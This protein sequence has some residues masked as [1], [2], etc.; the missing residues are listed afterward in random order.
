MA[1]RDRAEADNTRSALVYLS[2]GDRLLNQK[3][4]EE[5]IKNYKEV[6]RLL[7]RDTQVQ[8]MLGRIY[9]GAGDYEAAISTLE[10]DI[11]MLEATQP[12]GCKKIGECRKRAW[13]GLSSP[14][15]G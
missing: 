4:T 9:S 15:Q 11:R 6:G 13:T 12:A 5:A 7:P 2:L 3:D 8:S 10:A 1:E 14:W